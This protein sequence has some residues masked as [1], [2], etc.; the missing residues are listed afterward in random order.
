MQPIPRHVDVNGIVGQDDGAAKADPRMRA[1]VNIGDREHHI[2]LLNL[3][4]AMLRRQQ[5]AALE[6]NHEPGRRY[7]ITTS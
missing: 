6:E 7:P 3:S 5:T 2:G 1:P 4:N